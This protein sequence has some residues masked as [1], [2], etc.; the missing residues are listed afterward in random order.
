[1]ERENE[2]K[3]FKPEQFYRVNA[4]FSDKGGNGVRAELSRRLPSE[5]EH[6]NSWRHVRVKTSK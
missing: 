6:G 5:A 1:M 4:D 2:I 3:N